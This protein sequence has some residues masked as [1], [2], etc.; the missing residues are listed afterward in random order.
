M[1]LAAPFIGS[2]DGSEESSKELT[3]TGMHAADVVNCY[4]QMS[5][6]DLIASRGH[7][8]ELRNQIL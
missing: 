6:K 1:S 7:E 2:S 4:F 8:M 5:I 3:F